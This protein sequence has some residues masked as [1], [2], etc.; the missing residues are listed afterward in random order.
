MKYI[1]PYQQDKKL[2]VRKFIMGLNNRIGAGDALTPRT[3]GE[4]LDKV[5]RQE[6][7]IKKDDSI[8]DN[9]RKTKWNTEAED[10][11]SQIKQF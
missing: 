10:T 1:L 6:Y 5:V 11:G 4:A 2:K 7:K 3:V 9:K 8:R